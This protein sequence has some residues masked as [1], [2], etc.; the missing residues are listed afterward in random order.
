MIK[1]NQLEDT[2]AVDNVLKASSAK[3]QIVFKH[4]PRCSISVMALEKLEAAENIPDL[5]YY[6]IDVLNSRSVS[7]YLADKID[8]IHQSPQLIQL[9]EGACIMDKSHWEVDIN[10]ILTKE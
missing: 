10:S 2:E 9:R 7:L 4:S 3:D 8:L 1:W 6:M 5:D